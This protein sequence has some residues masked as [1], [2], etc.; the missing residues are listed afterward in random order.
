M[1]DLIIE[2]IIGDSGTRPRFIKIDEETSRLICPRYTDVMICIQARQLQ[3]VTFT[4]IE[5]I[6]PSIGKW[7]GSGYNCNIDNEDYTKEKLLGYIVSRL[8][9]FDK[10]SIQFCEK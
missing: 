3:S 8:R 4:N 6:H 10:C 1:K 7:E 5:F 9:G 2:F